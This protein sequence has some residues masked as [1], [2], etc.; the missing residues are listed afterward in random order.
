MGQALSI[1][2]LHDAS[3]QRPGRRRNRRDDEQR[4]GVF[5]RNEHGRAARIGPRSRHGLARPL[6]PRDVRPDEAGRRHDRES[7]PRRQHADALRRHDRLRPNA[8]NGRRAGRRRAHR[9]QRGLLD[10]RIPRPV[11]PRPQERR[12]R[13]ESGAHLRSARGR[14]GRRHEPCHA[15]RRRPQARHRRGRRAA[16]EGRDARELRQR[17]HLRRGREDRTLRKTRG[18]ER[19][20]LDERHP[21]DPVVRRRRRDARRPSGGGAHRRIPPRGFA[22]AGGFLD[23]G[24]L[25]R[26]ASFERARRFGPDR[27]QRPGDVLPHRGD[28]AKG[29][30]QLLGGRPDVFRLSRRRALVPA[31]RRE[32]D[33]ALQ[34]PEPRRRRDDRQPRRFDRHVPLVPELREGER[35]RP[36]QRRYDRVLRRAGEH[37]HARKSRPQVSGFE[38]RSAPHRLRL[39]QQHHRGDGRPRPRGRGTADVRGRHGIRHGQRR[40]RRRRRLDEIRRGVLRGPAHLQGRQRRAQGVSLDLHDVRPRAS[41]LLAASE[42]DEGLHRR[43]DRVGADHPVY[44]GAAHLLPSLHGQLAPPRPF[45]RLSQTQLRHRHRQQGRAVHPRARLLLGDER[46][47]RFYLRRRLQRAAEPAVQRREPVQTALRPRRRRPVRSRAPVR[48]PR[49]RMADRVEPFAAVLADRE[50]SQP[51]PVRLERRGAAGDQQ[52]RGHSAVHR[53]QDLL[54]GELP[55][56]V[57]RDEPQPVGEPGPEARR[58]GSPHAVRYDDAAESVAR[59]SAHVALVRRSAFGLRADR[60]GARSARDNLRAQYLRQ[61]HPERERRAE[62]LPSHGE[63]RRRLQPAAEVG[64]PRR[65]PFGEPSLELPEGNR[66]FGRYR[67]HGHRVHPGPR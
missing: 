45:V 67:R 39:A 3:R 62:T 6:R 65:Q 36:V 55:P 53:P 61:P 11:R 35:A 56:V 59:V 18:D 32:I 13:R 52:I 49:L 8:R 24:G 30:E 14:E 23:R 40:G 25:D 29:V 34:V 28:G 2:P 27:T 41:A 10:R 58:A 31:H 64:V 19:P 57:G 47:Y 50:P 16:R 54:D 60:L 63:L 33:G 17:R 4:G 9:R 1:P 48:S 12:R 43:Q 15:L 38:P 26:R 42:Q 22:V 37:R 66:E 20:L 44:R 7:Q 5:R 46:L 21:D 51:P